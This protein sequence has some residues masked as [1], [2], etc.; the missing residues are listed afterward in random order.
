MGRSAF[1]L[2][3]AALAIPAPA[4]AAP[5]THVVVVD[6]M[7]FG[8]VPRD[9]RTGDIIVWDNRDIFRHS[10]TAARAFDVDLPPGQR[11]KM[12]LTVTGD[13]RVLCKYHPG[14]KSRLKVA[15]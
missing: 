6:K 10:A 11:R 8:A 5:R 15:K 2:A 9:A 7:K 13:F 3:A 12:R 14:M 1:L 4:L